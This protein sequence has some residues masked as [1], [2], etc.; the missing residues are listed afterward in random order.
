MNILCLLGFHKWEKKLS[1]LEQVSLKHPTTISKCSRKGCRTR[2]VEK[3]GVM[4]V[5]TKIKI[6]KR[7]E[8][9]YNEIDRRPVIYK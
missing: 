9:I 1:D 5:T 3:E 2:I 8:V 4:K 6:Y 7:K